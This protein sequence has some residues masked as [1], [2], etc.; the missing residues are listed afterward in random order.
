MI[1]TG[2]L[3]I[4]E[5]YPNIRW[6]DKTWSE[7]GNGW[8]PLVDETMGRLSSIVGDD[9]IIKILQVKEK[10]GYLRIYT[11]VCEGDK[12]EEIKKVLLEAHTASMSICEQCGKSAT[13]RNL[14]GL[15]CVLCQECYDNER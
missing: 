5:R 10:L 1:D 14:G 6:E 3:E 15:L 9:H 7:V 12:E 8:L 13:L 4:S 11:D 2:L